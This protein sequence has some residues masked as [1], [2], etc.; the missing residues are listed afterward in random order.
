[1]IADLSYFF[2]LTHPCLLRI[3]ETTVSFLTPF[4]SQSYRLVCHSRVDHLEFRRL[5]PYVLHF[6]PSVQPCSLLLL[7]S[8]WNMLRKERTR[9]PY[10]RFRSGLFIGINLSFCERY[11]QNFSKCSVFRGSSRGSFRGESRVFSHL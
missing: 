9:P 7:C 4:Y 11:I 10:L 6:R 2:L 5:D 1:M 3:R 8:Y